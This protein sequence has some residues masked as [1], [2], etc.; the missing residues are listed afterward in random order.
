MYEGR[1]KDKYT[2]IDVQTQYQTFFYIIYDN[3]F[4]L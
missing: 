2:Q 4:P 1:Q 3:I